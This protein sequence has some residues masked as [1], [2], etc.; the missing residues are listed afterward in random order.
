MTP[1]AAQRMH[2]NTTRLTMQF[3]VRMQ[4]SRVIPKG[5]SGV[6]F[7]VPRFT[8]THEEHTGA[9][10]HWLAPSSMWTHANG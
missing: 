6:L 9:S 1:L 3:A 10:M 8:Q 4:P 5:D 7:D 2:S